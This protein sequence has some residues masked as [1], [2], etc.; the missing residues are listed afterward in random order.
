MQTPGQAPS[1]AEVQ[2]LA[3]VQEV[4][5]EVQAQPASPLEALAVVLPRSP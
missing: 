4:L 1:L 2:A 3:V 5:V